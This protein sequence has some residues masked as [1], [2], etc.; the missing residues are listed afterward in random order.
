MLLL[1]S[2]KNWIY[3]YADNYG[4]LYLNILYV[5]YVYWAHRYRYSNYVWK[6]NFTIHSSFYCRQ[7]EIKNTSLKNTCMLNLVILWAHACWHLKNSCKEKISTAV[8]TTAQRH[9]IPTFLVQHVPEWNAARDDP[10]TT[11]T[12]G[13]DITTSSQVKK[14]IKRI[15]L[16]HL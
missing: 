4:M 11:W 5:L 10:S 16:L 8:H 2:C 3:N 9:I 14:N 13:Q 6:E 1:T 12:R 7:L 15:Q